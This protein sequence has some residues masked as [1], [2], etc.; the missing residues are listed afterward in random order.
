M[1]ITICFHCLYFSQIQ[2]FS[3]S[4]TTVYERPVRKAFIQDR[5]FPL[6]PCWWSLCS[7]FKWFTLSNALLKS[8]RTKSVCLFVDCERYYGHCRKLFTKL[9]ELS[10]TRPPFSES[11][12]EVILYIILIKISG[13]AWSYDLL[14]HFAKNASQW[15]GAVVNIV[16][17]FYLPFWRL[18]W[19]MPWSNHEGPAL[20]L[21]ISWKV[22]KGRGAISLRKVFR[23]IGLMES[24]PY[25]L[26]SS[27]MMHRLIPPHSNSCSPC[28]P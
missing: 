21:A 13:Q 5:V 16:N 26:Q 2:L 28:F 3:P 23:T 1:H 24:G 25:A 4:R 22:L 6:T 10:F 27:F 9:N 17:C 19:H 11:V 8:S 7:S 20:S 18:G 12:L 14:H 15:Y